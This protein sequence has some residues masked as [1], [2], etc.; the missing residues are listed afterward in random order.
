MSSL[1]QQL[2]SNKYSGDVSNEIMQ[3]YKILG[4]GVFE[5]KFFSFSPDFEDPT[6]RTSVAGTLEHLQQNLASNRNFLEF[7]SGR[8]SYTYF[9]LLLLSKEF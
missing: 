9:K 1:M 5:Y 3:P 6:L 7:F 8:N 4:D 2:F